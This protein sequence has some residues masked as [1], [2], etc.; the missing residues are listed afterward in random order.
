MMTRAF[1]LSVGA[2]LLATCVPLLAALYL[3]SAD[4]DRSGT[5]SDITQYSVRKWSIPGYSYSCNA[6]YDK[7]HWRMHINLISLAWYPFLLAVFLIMCYLYLK[8]RGDGRAPFPVIWKTRRDRN[9]D[10]NEANR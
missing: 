1:K 10:E 7:P 8:F 5:Y 2:L 4:F 6:E 3:G 9:I